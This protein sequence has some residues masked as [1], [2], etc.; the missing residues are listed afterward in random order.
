MH[1]TLTEP[2]AVALHAARRAGDLSGRSVLI[3]GSGPIGLLTLVA[4]QHA[5]ARTVVTTDVIP[6]RRATAIALGAEAALDPA[7]E[8]WRQQLAEVVGTEEVDVAFDAVGI[9]DTFQQA[10]DSV[11]P[12]GTVVA[13]GGWRSVSLDL[14]RVVTRELQLQ[15]TFNFTPAEFDEARQWLE[16]GRLD[17]HCLVTDV[18]PLAEG[19]AVFAKLTQHR[20]GATKVVL[21]STEVNP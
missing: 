9:P 1:G 5:G 10:L 21:T 18:H 16:G 8:D 7:A 13:I 20:S 3:A 15:G 12:G 19:A 14:S 17:P 4:V 11:R 6:K 2:L